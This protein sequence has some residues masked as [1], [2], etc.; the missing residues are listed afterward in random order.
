MQ[1]QHKQGLL[2]RTHMRTSS[3]S[4]SS[5][6]GAS[7]GGRNGTDADGAPGNAHSHQMVPRSQCCHGGHRGA[8][9][10]A[11]SSPAPKR[12]CSPKSP[13][14]RQQHNRPR[15]ADC[16]G[17]S[18]LAPGVNWSWSRR[19]HAS[20]MLWGATAV[21]AAPCSSAPMLLPLASPKTAPGPTLLQLRPQIPAAAPTPRCSRAHFAPFPALFP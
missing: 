8:G 18:S 19:G 6:P 5:S 14:A 20:S 21:T 16:S 13:P 4:S 12:P 17:G 11:L 10:T 7:F 3:S 2:S 15:G 9:G 1:L